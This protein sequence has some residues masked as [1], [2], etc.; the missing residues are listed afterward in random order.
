M[1]FISKIDLDDCLSLMGDTEAIE[2]N[3]SRSASLDGVYDNIADEL[4]SDMRQ[5]FD[6]FVASCDVPSKY[7]TQNPVC[8]IM[9]GE[10]SQ[11]LVTQNKETEA[12]NPPVK[13][14]KRKNKRKMQSIFFDT[15]FFIPQP[16]KIRPNNDERKPPYTLQIER[17]VPPNREDLQKAEKR[18]WNDTLGIYFGSNCID[19]SDMNVRYRTSKGAL[20]ANNHGH[21]LSKLRRKNK[22]QRNEKDDDN[23]KVDDVECVVCKRDMTTCSDERCNMLIGKCNSLNGQHDICMTC[24]WTCCMLEP[25]DFNHF[26]NY[27]CPGCADNTLITLDEHGRELCLLKTRTKG[28]PSEFIIQETKVNLDKIN[29]S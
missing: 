12:K 1:F 29:G 20:I 17:V 6:E 26:K 14:K 19:G 21:G 25:S 13:Q 28:P 7:P 8:Q 10:D 15:E 18:Y 4:L 22:R 9:E 5:V 23:N 11:D 2:Y 27:K 3:L 16:S 24:Y